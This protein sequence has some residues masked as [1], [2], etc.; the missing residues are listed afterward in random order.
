M[1]TLEELVTHAQRR[2]NLE[3]ITYLLSFDLDMDSISSKENY[4]ILIRGNM[5]VRYQL[6]RYL[7][8]YSSLTRNI[9]GYFDSLEYAK[10]S[11]NRLGYKFSE[12]YFN[13]GGFVTTFTNFV[14]IRK[15][16]ENN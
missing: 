12:E 5:D 6:Y 8:E 11:M 14:N 15:T 13:S 2:L 7:Y 4:I 3:D 16:H 1:Y 9:F 10:N